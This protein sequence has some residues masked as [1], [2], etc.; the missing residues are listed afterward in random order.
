MANVV[1]NQY[2]EK[3]IKGTAAFTDATADYG[4][5]LVTSA[6]TATETDTVTQATAEEVSTSGYARKQLNNVAVT[7]V[8]VGATG[9]D[10]FFKVDAD[11]AVFGPSVTISAAG[12]VVFKK[13]TSLTDTPESIVTFVDFSGTKSSS[14]GDFTVVWNA[15]GILNYKQGV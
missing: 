1:Y 9:T 13:G 5:L 8:T 15:N 12:A 6:Y 2:K 7:K 3:M 11:N 4:V 14:A 10:D